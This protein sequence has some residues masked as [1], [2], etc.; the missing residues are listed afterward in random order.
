MSVQQLDIFVKK[1]SKHITESKKA[2]EGIHKTS[3]AHLTINLLERI[4]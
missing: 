1:V 4:S 3:Y 2:L